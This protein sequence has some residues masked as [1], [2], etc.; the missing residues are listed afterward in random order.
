MHILVWKI[1]EGFEL[2]QRSFLY[3]YT[4]GIFKQS[5]TPN[6][7]ILVKY[8]GWCQKYFTVIRGVTF[9]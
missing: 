2:A 8:Y 7:I 6:Q 5:S 4:I 9:S 1:S 3:L